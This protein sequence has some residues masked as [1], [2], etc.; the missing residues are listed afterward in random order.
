MEIK[1]LNVTSGVWYPLGNDL[2]NVIEKG[3]K[4][5]QDGK[6]VLWREEIKACACI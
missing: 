2:T 1:C 5:R 3:E 4:T 6:N